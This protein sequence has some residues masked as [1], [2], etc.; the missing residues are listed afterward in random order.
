MTE[1]NK[2]LESEFIEYFKTLNS[3]QR[4]KL[5]FDIEALAFTLFDKKDYEE[6]ITKIEKQLIE[7]EEEPINQDKADNWKKVFGEQK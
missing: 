2:K 7:K 6:E 1:E 5:A 3:K 4:F